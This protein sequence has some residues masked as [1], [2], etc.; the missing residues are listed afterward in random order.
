MA[1]SLE[2]QHPVKALAWAAKD[3][4]G[5]FAPLKFSR[6]ATGEHDVQF[7]VSYCGICHSDLHL[8]KNEWGSTIYPLIPGHEIAGVVTEVGNKVQ[9]FK[10]GDKVAVGCI[11]G[12]CRECE[13]CKI[14]EES[15]CPKHVLSINA[16]YY[17]GTVTYGGFSNLM[18]TNE[19]F[20]LRWPENFPLDKGAPLLCAG[21]TTYSP[22][23]RF[24]LDKP[25]VN[26]GVVGLG[27]IGH[28]TVKFAKALGSR[29]TVISTSISKKKEAIETFGADEF[30]VSHDQEQMQA[31]QGT[32]DGIIDTVSGDHSLQPLVNLLKPHGKLILVGLPTKLEVPVFPLILGGKSIV[33]TASGGV[34]ETQEMLDFAAKHS[35]LPDV[36]I[37]SMDYVN[38]A[39]HRIEKNDVK[40]RFVI[41]VGNSLKDE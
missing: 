15:Y 19:D 39:M 28:L 36:E 18:V 37:I 35:I 21:I 23:R 6:R 12:S 3:P 32:L 10:P 20:V 13:E 5:V 2:T 41:D 33:G 30:L 7:R 11:V 24:G 22:L 38:T 27:G 16:R 40:Y 17:D 26:V 31:A 25:G 34:K 14:N 29:V 9:K 8:A 1:T 4:S